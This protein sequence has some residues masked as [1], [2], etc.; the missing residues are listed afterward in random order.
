[1]FSAKLFATVFMY[2]EIHTDPSVS[3]S[4]SSQC[5]DSGAVCL[6]VAVNGASMKSKYVS[7]FFGQL[8]VY[9]QWCSVP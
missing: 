5:T 2:V 9:R 8:S 3:F 6:S 1:M 4:D 7:S